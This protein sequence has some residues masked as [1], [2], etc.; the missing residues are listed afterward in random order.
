MV[1]RSQRGKWDWRDYLTAP[2]GI[3]VRQAD[4]EA[5]KITKARAEWDKKYGRE[6][7]KIVNRAIQRAK[8]AQSQ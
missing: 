8:F 3:F 5:E 6:R 1:W 2:E 4:A 7:A